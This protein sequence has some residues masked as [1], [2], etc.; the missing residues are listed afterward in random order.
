MAYPDSRLMRMAFRA[1]LALWRMGLGPVIGKVMMVIGTTGRKSGLPRYAMAECHVIDGRKYAPCT[2]GERADWYRNIQADPYVTIQTA[3]GVERAKAR[4]VT[5]TEELLR[6]FCMMR[7][8]YPVMMDSYL[9][10]VGVRPDPVDVAAHKDRITFMAFDPTDRPT[11]PP[12][13]ADLKWL[14]VVFGVLVG[15]GWLLGRAS[16]RR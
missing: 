15:L 9:K 8:R 3:A 5:D 13:E 10:S 6:V 11:P 12:L 2:F 16:R 7:R 14:W 1:P 4:R